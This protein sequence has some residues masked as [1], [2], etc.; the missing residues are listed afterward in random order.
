MKFESQSER[1]QALYRR[2]LSD[3]RVREALRFIQEDEAATLEEQKKLC[4]VQAAPFHEAARA[5]VFRDCLVRYGADQARIDEEGNAYGWLRGNG[6]GPTVM[7]AAHLD[8]VFEEGTDTVVREKDGVLYAPGISDDTRGL[9]EVLSVL[10]ALKKS[11]IPLCG[12]LL[13][14]GNVGEE[15]LGDLRG[16]KYLFSKDPVA[17][18]FI[19]IDGFSGPETITSSGIGVRRYRISFN[20]PG[21]HSMW[22]FGTP[23]AVHAM[24]RAIAEIA[25]LQ[26]PKDP[27]TTFTIGTAEGGTSVNVIARHAEMLIDLRSVSAGELRRVE[28]RVKEICRKA[29]REENSQWNSSDITVEIEK[30]GDRPAGTQLDDAPIVA[31]ALEATRSIGLHPRIAA[32]SST[33][34]NIPISLGIPAVTLDCGGKCFGAHTL[35][36]H[37]DPHGGYLGPQRALLLLL[38]LAGIDKRT[39]PVLP[40]KSYREEKGI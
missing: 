28:E 2:M 27:F 29:A 32:P 26:V 37:Y 24:G 16:V 11:A 31:A 36:E 35:E 40:L 21:G 38:A 1:N 30:K 18:A 39:E 6:T 23:S 10:R 20:G 22:A 8:T 3:S 14:C 4:A 12:D 13:F 19:S 7:L 34:S 5:A 17:D 15:G 25:N 9:A 33:D